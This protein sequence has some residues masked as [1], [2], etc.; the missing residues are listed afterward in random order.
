M[1]GGEPTLAIPGWLR[2]LPVRAVL[3]LGVVILFQLLTRGEVE[4]VIAVAVAIGYVGV[5]V[6]VEHWQRGTD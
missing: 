6:V 2:S 1:T 3:V 4:P 5:S